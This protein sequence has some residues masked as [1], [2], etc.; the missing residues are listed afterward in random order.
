MNNL[1]LRFTCVT[2][3]RLSLSKRI[4]NA[5]FNKNSI[6]GASNAFGTL[7]KMRA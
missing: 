5:V 1:Q 3:T 7:E 2:N 4:D 6:I